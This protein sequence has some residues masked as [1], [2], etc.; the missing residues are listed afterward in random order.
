MK[1][2]DQPKNALISLK[3][4]A[5]SFIIHEMSNTHNSIKN[6]LCGFLLNSGS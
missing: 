1:Y 6:A 4:Y 5:G 3:I 2:I